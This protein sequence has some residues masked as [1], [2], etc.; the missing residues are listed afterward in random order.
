MYW[1]IHW[2]EAIDWNCGRTSQINRLKCNN[3][4]MDTQK[5]R[6]QKKRQR[7]RKVGCPKAW[8]SV[9]AHGPYG[10]PEILK[11]NKQTCFNYIKENDNNNNNNRHL[12]L[13]SEFV[14]IIRLLRIDTFNIRIQKVIQLV[15]T[16]TCW[17]L[18]VLKCLALIIIYD[19]VLKASDPK[20]TTI[21]K[22]KPG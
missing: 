5:Q 9:L 4:H 1:A 17:S 2:L 3:E 8:F 6:G 18:I 15:Y 12:L 11:K 14:W 10:V 7:Q 20:H 21:N 13:P 16:V 19:K 22:S